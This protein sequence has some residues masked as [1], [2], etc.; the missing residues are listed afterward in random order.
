MRVR[1]RVRLRVRV[2]GCVTLVEVVE[3]GRLGVEVAVDLV[4][5]EPARLLLAPPV[6]EQPARERVD[7]GE[8]RAEVADEPA[9]VEDRDVAGDLVRVRVRVQG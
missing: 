4:V 2:W 5:V 1:V 6:A 3:L 9:Q 8:R 7:G